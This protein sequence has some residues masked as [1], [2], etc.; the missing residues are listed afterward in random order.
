MAYSAAASDAATALLPGVKANESG[1]TPDDQVPPGDGGRSRGAY[2][3]TAGALDDVNR[4]FGTSYTAADLDKPA[5]N[6]EVAQKYLT[7]QVQR[8]GPRVGLEA[9]NAGPTRVAAGDT[10]QAAVDY[11]ARA[12]NVGGAGNTLAGDFG[13]FQKMIGTPDASWMA[14]TMTAL[15]ADLTA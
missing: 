3:V 13:T 10:P 7:L 4:A 15:R 11:A 8:F 12:L 1:D 2:Q 6:K 9:Y 5:V 14:P